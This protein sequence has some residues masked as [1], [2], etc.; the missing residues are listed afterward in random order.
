MILASLFVLAAHRS[1]PAFD[2]GPNPMLMRNPTLSATA[3]V[4]QFA[5][6]LWSVP[7][8]GGDATRLTNSPGI[9]SNPVFSPDGQTIAFTGQYDG[10]TDVYT[11]PAE[12]GVP[13]R[14]TAHPSDDKVVGWTPDGSRV[15]FSSNML[16][17]TDYPRLLMVSKTGGM[18]KALPFPA[19]VEG[20]MSADGKQIAYVPNGKWQEAWKRYRGGQTTPIWVAQ[21]SDSKWK[22]IP[23]KNTNDKNPMWIGDSVYYLTDPTG[24]VGMNRYDVKSGKVTI[25]IPGEGFDLK[26]ASAGP[27]AIVYERLGSINLFDLKT[28]KSSRVSIQIRG[29]F[30]E[31]RT[32]IKDVRSLTTGVTLSPSGQR[33][34]VAARGW[35][36]TAPAAKG[37]V[38]LLGGKQGV[39]R[40]EPSWSPDGKTIAYIS[41]E[42]G[43]QKLA[44]YDVATATEKRVP[45]A[46]GSGYYKNLV[47]SPDSQKIAYSSEKLTLNIFDVA[48][49]KNTT[50]DKQTYRGRTDINA[51]WSPDSM[52]LTW[53]RDLENLYSAV[54]LY[55][56][57]TGK[58]TQI[59]DGMADAQNPIFDRDGKHLYF[60]AST[61]IGIGAHFEDVS[62]LTAAGATSSVYAVVLRKDLPNPLQPE[63]DEEKPK[64]AP[65]NPAKP[66]AKP[67]FNIDLDGI[68]RRIIVL[69]MPRQAYATLEP[70]PAG[71]FFAIAGGGRGAAA[72]PALVKFGFSDRK[73][74]KFL[75]GVRSVASNPDGSKL[76][77]QQ[78]AGLAIISSMAPPAPGQG[79]VD[80]SDLKVKIDPRQEWAA[81]F[82]E[83][84]R[85]EK[86]LLYAPNLH[87]IDATVMEKRYEP[88]LANV[89][90]RD[91]LNYLFTDML[92]ELCVGHMF[93]RGGDMPAQKR[94]V[95]G[96]L[97]ADYSFE[98][99]RYRLTKI[100]DGERWNPNLT[101]PLAQPGV[102]A[103]SGEYLLAIDGTELN[104]A[105]DIYL[106]L[107]GKAGKQ[108]KVK[109]G[110]TP[111]GVGAR[112]VTVVP[113]AN[114]FG[115]RFRSWLEDN[116]RTIEK[117]T[118]G[119]VGY[120]HVPD[121]GGGGFEAF[122]RYFYSQTTKE[123][124]IVDDR[125]NHGGL[126]NDFMVH[127]ME[128]PLDFIDKA[129]Y[130]KRMNDPSAA[131]YGP[132]VM[133]VNEMAGSG[134][135]I[136]PY[137]FKLHKVGKLVGRRTWG[138]MI[139]AS[140][141][142][143]PDGGSI[144]APDDAMM[145]ASTGQWVIENEGVAPDI[146]VELD[147][148]L[149]RQGRDAQLEAAIEQ[150]KKDMAKMKTN[151]PEL[152][153]FPDKSKLPTKPG[154][155]QGG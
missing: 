112:E 70:G 30:P 35:I 99:G 42:D 97:G 146:E 66:D 16:S 40:R 139:S 116:R 5:G 152:A 98:N 49:G 122:L 102:E 154:S 138:A 56:F 85:N 58:V 147:P 27:G 20:S 82:H 32:N 88:F 120:V 103:K 77:I 127:E 115:L 67:P 124:L 3:I 54:F 95:G 144:T 123:G 51:A 94:V 55:S 129:R 14:L 53:C 1:D 128:K 74:V 105:M 6:D 109:L 93:I 23:R 125:F 151:K 33:V 73:V 117:A 43:D 44:L 133:L 148:Y 104:D 79:V 19:G 57:A 71:S 126:V 65:P 75:D 145:L 119:R 83:I 81:M 39:N 17:N 100:Y 62:T 153:P 7:R 142:P 8:A 149:W 132:K 80:L 91:D 87:G 110:P 22:A 45:I 46:D 130:G 76:L 31:V 24:P 89:V 64:A 140:G 101:A 37:D 96:L 72:P 9:E 134:G 38:R 12:G 137:I 28:H 59:T 108:V 41:D 10:N 143:L 36:F 106:E 136:F 135:D 114:E 11:I 52:W 47:W 50:I 84:W 131:I 121:T 18:P 68:E 63:S 90:S 69:P 92:G 61:D 13:Q 60:T 78:A 111:D 34:V 4:F 86:L 26:S 107:E 25:E 15:I 21:L 155:K 2:P 118:D 141:F 29:D 113:I 48:S 150:I